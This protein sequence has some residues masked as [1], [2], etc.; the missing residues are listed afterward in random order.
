L[1]LVKGFM[2]KLGIH[3]VVPIKVNLTEGVLVEPSF[4]K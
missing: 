1:I 3:E 2:D 4:W